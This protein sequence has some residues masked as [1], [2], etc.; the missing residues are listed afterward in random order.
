MY[1]CSSMKLENEALDALKELDALQNLGDLEGFPILSWN[2]VAGAEL[3]DINLKS[4]LPFPLGEKVDVF[5]NEKLPRDTV[6]FGME[7]FDFM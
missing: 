4:E 7:S 6:L 5:L 3:P 2:I 1:E